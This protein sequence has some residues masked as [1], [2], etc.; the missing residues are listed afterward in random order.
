MNL[1][2]RE[3]FGIIV[4]GEETVGVIVYGLGSPGGVTRE[5]PHG[6]CPLGPVPDTW[7]LVG[8]HWEITL[9]SIPIPV[10]PTGTDWQH[11]LDATLRLMIAAGA[12]VAWVGGEVMRYADPPFLFLPED[13]YGGVPAWMTD[14]G[15]RGGHLDPDQPFTPATD[16]ELRALRHYAEGLADVS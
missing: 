12:K 5:P 16:A 7:V 6:R 10:W 14:D 11:R 4:G 9:W 1:P 2:A 3:C 13:M 8:E 15:R